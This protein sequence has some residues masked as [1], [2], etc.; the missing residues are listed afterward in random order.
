MGQT[1]FVRKKENLKKNIYCFGEKGDEKENLPRGNPDHHKIV[2]YI[3]IH[4]S[5]FSSKPLE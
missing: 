4:I 5:N 3:K 2:P 1:D